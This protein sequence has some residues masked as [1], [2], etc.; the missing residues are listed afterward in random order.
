METCVSNVVML[1]N[2]ASSER[3]CY[4]QRYIV[5]PDGNTWPYSS[6][7][8]LLPDGLIFYQSQSEAFNSRTIPR[9]Y[10]GSQM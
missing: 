4:M 8:L 10:I 5:D 3:L 6:P 7:Y 1:H 9:H 2:N